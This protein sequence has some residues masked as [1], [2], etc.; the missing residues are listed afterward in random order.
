MKPEELRI[1]NWCLRLDNSEF[2]IS[3]KDISQIGGFPER[4]R[5]NPIPLTEEWLIKFGWK[6]LLELAIH[7]NENAMFEMFITVEIL[8]TMK[9]HQLQN[10]YFA[11]TG[12]E[13]TIKE[14]VK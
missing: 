14:L 6:S 5:P 7:I 3:G 8:R 13:P 10:L 4:L 9:V 12:E 11:L 1:G 2:Q